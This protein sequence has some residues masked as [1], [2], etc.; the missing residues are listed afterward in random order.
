[1][2]I[3]KPVTQIEE[4]L[5]DDA[6][7]ISRTNTK[8]AISF[9]NDEFIKISGFPK[10]ELEG[11]NHNVVRHPD[12]PPEAFEDL[13][14]T[15]KTG[16]SWK[17]VVKNRCKNGNFYW[18]NAHITPVME[19]QQIVGFV[20]VRS[21]ASREEINQAS[22]LYKRINQGQVSFPPTLKCKNF[23][24]R[25]LLEKKGSLLSLIGLTIS[26]QIASLLIGPA[27]SLFFSAATI[28]F[29]LVG[30]LSFL[31]YIK[32]CT[33][34]FDKR[35]QGLF[36][37]LGYV[38]TQ[39]AKSSTRISEAVKNLERK[40][41]ELQEINKDQINSVVKTRSAI[42]SLSS[43]VE[44]SASM[45]NEAANFSEESRDH[46]IEGSAVMQKTIGAMG[47][48]SKGSDDISSIIGVIDEIAF[49]TNLLALNASVEAAHAGELGR[50][51]AIVADEVR[52]LSHR[53]TEA[54]VE[55][56]GLISRSTKEVANGRDLVD[57][58][59]Q[60]LEEIIS[61]SKHVGSIVTSIS[62]GSHQ[63]H[64]SLNS[65]NISMGEMETMTTKNSELV[66]K[67]AVVSAL[68]SKQS[69]GLHELIGF[70]HVDA[71]GERKVS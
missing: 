36:D 70:F 34:E 64:E 32:S 68:L 42:E 16:E 46:A 19:N 9:S 5:E 7:L 17:G 63:Q 43:Q 35:E 47:V 6:L 15:I 48:I 14:A 66:E 54:A 55:I 18:V 13:W 12:M 61:S 31:F 25:S 30:G 26:L 49:Q 8:G 1:M 45:A 24:F 65:V 10:E 20:S 28:I 2:K 53:S 57:K 27:G 56:K 22:D 62:E 23:S 59:D 69:E 33:A 4:I 50:G 51:F 41:V 21:K 29:C 58:S 52:T 67:T 11:K 37:K 60:Q 71:I 44:T 39:T 3:N 40:N 38:L